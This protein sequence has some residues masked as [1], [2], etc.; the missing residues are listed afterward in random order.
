MSA[1]KYNITIE[2]GATFNTEIVYKDSGSNPIDLSGYQARLQ[3][4]PSKGSS[5]TYLTL[6]SSLASDGTGLNMSGSTGFKPP[7]SGSIGIYISALSSSLLTF[8]GE[9]YYDLEL[10]Y[11][12]IYPVVT[13]LLEG[14]AKLS[15][16]V[17][18]GSYG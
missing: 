5:T 13:R 2:Q 7:T 3:I 15:L 17:T 12:S 9:A 14:Q 1:G 4:K 11:G 6:S 18:T 8:T 10:V 16:E